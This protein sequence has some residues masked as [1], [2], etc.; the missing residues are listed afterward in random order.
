MSTT[1]VFT[2]GI[3]LPVVSPITDGLNPVSNVII[4]EWETLGQVVLQKPIT[5]DIIAYQISASQALAWNSTQRVEVVPTFGF[6]G[7]LQPVVH[8][9]TERYY[10]PAFAWNEEFRSGATQA[11]KWNT[12]TTYSK[13]LP[14][15]WQTLFRVNFT[16]KAIAW[17]T[18]L[19]VYVP[20]VAGGTYL[21]IDMPTVHPISF[22]ST[23][24]HTM[25]WNVVQNLKL[26]QGIRWNTLFATKTTK[27]TAW[28]TLAIHV[29]TTQ[30]TTWFT[31][32]KVS[33]TVR[34]TWT[35]FARIN[36][37]KKILWNTKQAIVAQ[38]AAHWNVYDP[39]SKSQAVAWTLYQKIAEKPVF[40]WNVFT[41]RESVVKTSWNTLQAIH[42][43]R[44]Q[45]L[46]ASPGSIVSS[47]VHPIDVGTPALMPYPYQG[48]ASPVVHPIDYNPYSGYGF[49][50]QPEFAW[51]LGINPNGRVVS[52][53]A[54]AWNVYRPV[55]PKLAVAW[56]TV[57]RS[58]SQ[59]KMQW[60]VRTTSAAQVIM[61]WIVGQPVARGIRQTAVDRTDF[62]Y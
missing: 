8:P 9:I 56:N 54:T 47:V 60:N 37:K 1:L 45:Y 30:A 61:E 3:C 41:T 46:S 42:V 23:P 39:V 26:K 5:W 62:T 32:G 59:Q 49:Y 43:L 6:G 10:T 36:G 14:S 25:A 57:G 24:T 38:K 7:L 55:D 13:N 44:P 21:Q 33:P 27:Q 16:Q 15:K 19:R 34:S 29:T 40:K 4:S 11:I 20:G 12:T 17:N 52:Q 28:N 53:Q 48:L 35:T 18:L 22:Y 31:Y 51:R 2:P 58:N 50:P